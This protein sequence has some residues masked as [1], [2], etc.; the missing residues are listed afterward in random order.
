MAAKR[1]RRR[2]AGSFG[3]WLAV[4][5]LA[6]AG[7]LYYHPFTTYLE[8]RG[9]VALRAGEVRSLQEERESLERRLQEQR[10]EGTIVLDARRMAYVRPG[11]QL[12]IV[13]GIPEWRRAQ[14]AARAGAT[15][16]GD[17]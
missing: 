16:G 17:G 14:A 10:S 1:K 11:E 12:F 15:I 4:C 8:K 3:R 6:A 5:A 13:K 9:E 2:R 7:F